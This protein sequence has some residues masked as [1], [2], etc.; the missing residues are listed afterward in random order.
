MSHED[1]RD[2]S[3]AGR[4]LLAALGV[5]LGAVNVAANF[6]LVPGSFWLA[7]IVGVE[8]GWLLAGF[9]ACWGGRTWREAFTRSMTLLLPAVIVYVIAD[10]VMIARTVDGTISGP[11]AIIIEG[12]F[13]S[14]AAVGASVGLAT[15]RRLIRVDGPIGVLAA[16]ALPTDIAYSVWSSRRNLARMNVDD[17]AMVDV[18]AVVL[19]SAVVVAIVAAAARI[20]APRER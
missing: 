18:A 10:A 7:K 4:A 15:I 12:I 13:W 3:W 2:G 19:P 9:A 17:P 16:A 5:V 14:I 6:G 11:A 20:L 8:W 1:G